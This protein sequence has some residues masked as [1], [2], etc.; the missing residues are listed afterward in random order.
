MRGEKVTFASGARFPR[1]YTNAAD[2]AQL[3]VKLLDAPDEA[4]YRGRLSIESGRAI[5]YEPRFR[6]IRDGLADYIERY[7]AFLT[8]SS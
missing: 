1:D 3:A 8:S 6:S 5:G 2:V 4:D 7:R